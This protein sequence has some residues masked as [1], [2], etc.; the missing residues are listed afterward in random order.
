MFSTRAPSRLI[1]ANAAPDRIAGALKAN[2]MKAAPAATPRMASSIIP[3]SGSTAKAWTLVSTPERTRNAPSMEKVKARMARK[4]VHPASA[5]RRSVTMAECSRAAPASHGM[6][7]AFS[8]GSQ[9][10]QPPQPSS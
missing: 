6:K 10:H 7:L 9:N 1:G 4:T 8:T 5:P 2:R 3:R